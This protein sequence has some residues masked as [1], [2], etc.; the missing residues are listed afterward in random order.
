MYVDCRSEGICA[1]A[2]A[3][4]EYPDS[5]GKCVVFKVA[6][7][8]TE[9]FPRSDFINLRKA[10]ANTLK[11]DEL[12]TLL[13]TFQ[14][15]KEADQISKIESEL[16]ETKFIIYKTIES[17][18]ERGEKLDSLVAKSDELSATSKM[19]YTQVRMLQEFESFRLTKLQSR[20]R[21]R[22]RAALSC[23]YRFSIHCGFPALVQSDV[24]WIR[25]LFSPYPMALNII[26]LRL[27]VLF[28]RCHVRCAFLNTACVNADP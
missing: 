11:W 3:D 8:F 7:K 19:F 27:I 21:N 6:D 15:P 16:A 23:E 26:A 22:T 4:L 10:D 17:V 24:V 25:Y 13:S 9:A 18:L 2:I 20:Q 28:S 12:K 14:D 5:A 1:F